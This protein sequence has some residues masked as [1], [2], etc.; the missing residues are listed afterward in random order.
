MYEY[1][2]T[3][4]AAGLASYFTNVG[5]QTDTYK[6]L[7]KPS[8]F[9]PGYAFGVAWTIIYIL[10]AI[11]WS[12]GKSIPLINFT[13]FVNIFLN[14]L[15][16]FVFFYK[17]LFKEALYVLGFLDATLLTQIGLLYKPSLVSSVLLI[18]YLGW[19]F[20]ATYLNYTINTLN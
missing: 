20:F 19:S 13:F 3:F 2:L 1:I 14:V 5:L 7:K 15:W 10:F 18:P 17:G 12:Y 6:N 4:L 9:P 8:W 16:C 11:S